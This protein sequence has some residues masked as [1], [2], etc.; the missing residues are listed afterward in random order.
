LET[1]SRRKILKRV[2]LF[3]VM[4]GFVTA[5]ALCQ[6]GAPPDYS[7]C[8]FLSKASETELAQNTGYGIDRQGDVHNQEGRIVIWDEWAHSA[9]TGKGIGASS[10]GQGS[11]DYG[12]QRATFSATAK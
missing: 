6:A 2:W 10:A 11:I 4:I 9:M 1:T 7:P 12:Q 8:A 5:P 3:L